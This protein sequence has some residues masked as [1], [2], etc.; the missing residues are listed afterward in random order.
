MSMGTGT[1][2]KGVA[3]GL[4]LVGLESPSHRRRYDP[5]ALIDARHLYEGVSI[6][7]DHKDPRKGESRKAIESFGIAENVRFVEGKGLVADVRFN[8][9]HPFAPV[10]EGAIEDLGGKSLS[11]SHHLDEATAVRDPDGWMRI[12]NIPSVGSV[13]IVVKGATTTTLF[14]ENGPAPT[15]GQHKEEEMDFTKLTLAQLTES[16]PDLLKSIQDAVQSDQAT[17]EKLTQLAE[18]VKTLTKSETELK[19]KLDLLKAGTALTER[20]TVRLKSIEEAKLPKELDTELFRTLA[21]A[22]NADDETFKNL[23]EERKTMMASFGGVRSRGLPPGSKQ[24][25]TA[26]TIGE[27]PKD[28]AARVRGV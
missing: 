1:I 9:K 15:S 10:F 18:Q 20:N 12:I 3:K 23:L 24:T 17:T 13:D 5:Q 14:E 28:F 7:I 6:F 2:E 11:F 4:L 16:R 8:T 19:N 21:T 25:S 22:E 26:P 27:T